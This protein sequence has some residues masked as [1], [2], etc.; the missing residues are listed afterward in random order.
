MD[1]QPSSPVQFGVTL[2]QASI[3]FF[4]CLCA[5]IALVILFCRKKF[6]EPSVERNE[7]DYVSQL[8]PR[9]LATREEYSKGLLIYMGS[10]AF[11]VLMLALI[12]PKPLSVFGVNIPPEIGNAAVP[13][14][15]ALVLVGILPNVPVL[16][17]IEKWLR[18]YAHEQAFIPTAARAT[19]EKLSAADFDFAAYDKKEVLDA[20]EM[21]GVK[22]SDFQ[23]SRRSLEHSWA[24]LSCLVYELKWRRMA[25][26][27]DSLD[28]DLLRSYATDLDSIED[29]K[30]S[31]EAEVARY[32][33][34]NSG[35]ATHAND[36]LHRTIR[37]TLYKLYIL[38]GCA[39]RLKAKPNR[40][41]NPAL[42]SFGFAL[43]ATTNPPENRDLTLVGM[44]VMSASVLVI[45]F[46]AY[47]LGR[48]GLWNVSELFPNAGY[49][50]FVIMVSAAFAHGLAILVADLVRTRRI[51]NGCWFTPAGS[52]Q[53][54]VSAN[55]IRVALAS[56]AVGY[57]AYILWGLVFQGGTADLFKEAAPHALLP[58]ATGGF[59]AYHLDNVELCRRPSRLW[60][61]AP[62]A[63]VTAFCGLAA[64]SASVGFTT[65][66]PAETLDQIVL[67]TVIGAAIGAS[68]AW[69]IPAA[70]STKSDP[71]AEAREERLRMLT[72]AARNR[73]KSPGE[74]EQWIARP[75]AALGNKPPQAAANDVEGYEQALGLL[76]A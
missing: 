43:T 37:S 7:E 47:V 8:L 40:D 27:V 10:M 22:S 1:N 6:N 53:K 17:E 44:A 73:F 11:T 41:I 42:R 63:L 75:H 60:E 20:A 62:Q 32:R 64:A 28:G 35:N 39:V 3:Y 50:P 48:L 25:G 4:I 2:D 66:T 15:V 45:A 72:A 29:K 38:L 70:A 76:A 21:H 12:G 16:Q 9:H 23:R 61:V 56:G 59:L 65:Y 49:Q 5:A 30:K 68:F 74:A 34:K 18:R 58:A 24:R 33:S 26:L 36:T 69:Y 19:A 52:T 13:L 31:L 55:Y 54:A 71:L 57:A 67:I 14:L 46:A 51:N